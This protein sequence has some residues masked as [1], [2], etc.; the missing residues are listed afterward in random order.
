MKGHTDAELTTEVRKWSS[1][2]KHGNGGIEV[3]FNSTA[4]FA[5]L[6]I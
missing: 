3:A 4:Q 5:K 6:K 1:S 2:E